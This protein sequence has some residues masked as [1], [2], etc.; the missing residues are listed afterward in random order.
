MNLKK[1]YYKDL[2]SKVY[3]L[4]RDY[5]PESIDVLNSTQLSLSVRH[6][7][8]ISKGDQ[9]IAIVEIKTSSLYQRDREDYKRWLTEYTR[10]L[11][12]RY[13]IL[14][15]EDK[16]F[17]LKDCSSA[18]S[19]DYEEVELKDICNKL[20]KINPPKVATNIQYNT[21]LSFGGHSMILCHILMI[22]KMQM[23]RHLL[24]K[25]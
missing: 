15:I 22:M 2:E 16:T 13:A 11:G 4:F 1:I 5:L 24:R 14:A 3:K 18:F 6:D 8:T 17:Y 12:F 20:V 7:I 23:G 25:K 9:R 10:S 19:P 21:I